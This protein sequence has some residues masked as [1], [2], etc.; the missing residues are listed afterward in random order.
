MHSRRR[1]SRNALRPIVRISDTATE[2]VVI[3][4]DPISPS[5]IGN[6]AF[7]LGVIDPPNLIVIPEVANGTMMLDKGETLAI[8]RKPERIGPHIADRNAVGDVACIRPRAPVQRVVGVSP[9]LSVDGARKLNSAGIAG[10]G[11]RSMSAK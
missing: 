5:D 4:H 1:L 11:S 10:S 9:K 8:Q 7:R 3:H 2:G 6:Q